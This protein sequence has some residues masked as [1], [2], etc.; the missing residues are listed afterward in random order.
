MERFQIQLLSIMSMV[1]LEYSKQSIYQFVR[2]FHF[3]IFC[4][5]DFD[6]LTDFQL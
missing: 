5:Y 3:V 6:R 4:K 1:Y 2:D